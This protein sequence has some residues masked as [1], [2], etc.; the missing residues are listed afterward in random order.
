MSIVTQHTRGA[1][2]V[3]SERDD[4]VPR[5]PAA[6]ATWCRALG[7]QAVVYGTPAALQYAQLCAQVLAPGAPGRLAA[8]RHERIPAGPDFGAFRAPNVDTLYSNAWLDLRGGPAELRLP[9]FGDRYA[10]VQ[11]LDAHSNAANVN[12]RTHPGAS[13]F[14][15]VSTGWDGEAPAGVTVV[16]V[17]TDLVWLLLRIQVVDD[18]LGA[19]HRLQ[20]AVQ[21]RGSPS[22]DDL[23][24]VVDADAVEQ[25]WRVFYRALDA[26]L[27]LGGVPVQDWPSVRPFAALGLLGPG[28]WDPT[29]LDEATANALADSFAAAQEILR[30]SRPQLGQSTGTGWT[31]VRDKGAHGHNVLARAVMNHVGLAA[32]LAEE[33]TSFN[34]HVDVDGAPLAGSGGP[35]RLTFDTS[36]PAQAFWSVTLYHVETGR[37]YAN[38][39]GRYSL[40]SASPLL[41]ATDGPV[42]M[43]IAHRDPGEGPWLP[44]PEADFYLVLRIYA[45][46]DAARDGTWLPAPVVP[47][48]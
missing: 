14:W 37:L 43:T 31:R 10:T 2:L 9:A 1:G 20:D 35:Y 36:P 46:G 42:G 16:R 6:R 44:C 34:T 41:V 7:L 32:N 47:L 18:D 25:D 13:R 4:L 5:D 22:V 12:A 28:R 23:G 17:A 29:D 40:G 8:F 30:A 38:S 3:A 24:P 15:L 26:A 39:L 19:V 33:N 45:P 48:G 27:R 21:L 11:V